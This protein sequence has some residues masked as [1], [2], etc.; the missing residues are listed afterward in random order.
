MQ[1]HKK[2]MWIGIDVDIAKRIPKHLKI[3]S[4]LFMKE[5]F[6]TNREL[7]K[8]KGRLVSRGDMVAEELKE[9]ID[10]PT[11]SPDAVLLML[12]V[13]AMEGRQW[14]SYDVPAAYTNAKRDPNS[15]P[16]YMVLN[17]EI[18]TIIADR[19]T[20]FRQFINE[21][22][23][24][25]VKIMRAAY[26]L[27]DSSGLW[28]NEVSGFLKEMGF[29]ENPVSPCVFN[30]MINHRQATILLYVDDMLISHESINVVESIMDD[31]DNKY[32][33]GTRSQGKLVEFLGM[34]IERNED[35]SISISMPKHIVDLLDAWKIDKVSE[36]PAGHDLFVADEASPKLSKEQSEK[37][38]S[39]VAS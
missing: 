22:G 39:G 8:V 35:G 25:L 13:F 11:V 2:P 37:L 18:S 17:K 3:Q 6:N 16:I 33:K 10:S 29:Q 36:Y 26:G 12:S 24:S 9:Y 14:A 23:T 15:N 30:K 31:T 19:D 38:H 5:K 20:E 1:L 4:K 34:R 28:Y 27:S 32:G 7:E 21:K